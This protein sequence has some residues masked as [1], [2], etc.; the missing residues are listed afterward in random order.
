MAQDFLEDMALQIA[1]D[2]GDPR[3]NYLSDG[4][5]ITAE[6]LESGITEAVIELYE[7]KLGVKAGENLSTKAAS[8]FMNK[9]L[10][11]RKEEILSRTIVD[12]PLKLWDKPSE[13]V[14]KIRKIISIEVNATN[15]LIQKKIASPYNDEQYQ[16]VINNSY[17]N[18]APSTDDIWF[19][20][21]KTQVS[22]EM[23]T[24]TGG[25]NVISA[26]TLKLICLTEPV[27]QVFGVTLPDI[28]A[29]RSWR[30]EIIELSKQIILGSH[31]Q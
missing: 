10:D 25:D 31:Q 2:L 19:Y 3:T 17:S 6:Q 15:P 26:G 5:T 28:L 23:G 27:K 4:K 22:L 8:G 14:T 11:Y 1:G 24:G 16:S 29:P 21:Y 13:D 30:S 9:Y 7:V 20:E 12:P 18:Y